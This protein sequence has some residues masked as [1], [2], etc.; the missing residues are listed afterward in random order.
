MYDA[1]HDKPLGKRAQDIVIGKVKRKGSVLDKVHGQPQGSMKLYKNHYKKAENTGTLHKSSDSLRKGEHAAY[2]KKASSQMGVTSNQKKEEEGVPT[3]SMV[4]RSTKPSADFFDDLFEPFVSTGAGS[5][6]PDGEHGDAPRRKAAKTSVGGGSASSSAV[7]KAAAKAVA[8]G[9]S[10][11]SRGRPAAGVPATPG[12]TEK[13]SG[14]TEKGRNSAFH[15]SEQVSLTCT[16]ALRN[17]SDKHFYASLSPAYMQGLV[18]KVE[19]RLTDVLIFEYSA[20]YD[21]TPLSA[22]GAAHPHRGMALIRM[23]HP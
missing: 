13:K 19:E 11:G 23:T 2:W 14:M 6:D 10:S 1:H 3:Q 21:H 9:G 4:V 12:A 20:G 22:A 17:F 16:Q 15:T 18:K 5:K 7:A 8:G